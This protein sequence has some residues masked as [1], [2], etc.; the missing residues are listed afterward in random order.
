MITDTGKRICDKEIKKKG[1][2]C[3]CK[4][5][6]KYKIK[7]KVSSYM[8]LD[9]CSKHKPRLMELADIEYTD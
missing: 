7:S 2:W 8:E 5:P 3:S 9:Y 1:L 4:K 6:A